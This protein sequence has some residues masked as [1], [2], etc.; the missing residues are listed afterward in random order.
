MTVTTKYGNPFDSLDE[1]DLLLVG[2]SSEVEPGG[3]VMNTGLN[4]LLVESIDN[5]SHFLGRQITDGQFYGFLATEGKLGLLQFGLDDGRPDPD[6]LQRSLH[7]MSKWLEQHPETRVFIESPISWGLNKSQ[8]RKLFGNLAPEF[9]ITLWIPEPERPKRQDEPET[10]FE[11]LCKRY[12]ALHGEP[13]PILAGQDECTKT[14]I[15]E[16]CK[17]PEAADDDLFEVY[18]IR[19]QQEAILRCFAFSNDLLPDGFAEEVE[20]KDHL[21]IFQHPGIAFPEEANEIYAATVRVAENR[22]QPAMSVKIDAGALLGASGP[23]STEKAP[24]VPQKPPQPPTPS[25]R[26]AELQ[27]KAAANK[28]AR[29]AKAQESDKPKAA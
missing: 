23:D 17:A 11:A 25:E 2:G 14:S 12:T 4:A 5:I 28:A 8:V 6:I 19:D 18:L 1:C 9:H 10:Y 27:A 20:V 21:V 15:A 26:L 13:E 7:T 29:E 3:L 24:V 22:K 16:L